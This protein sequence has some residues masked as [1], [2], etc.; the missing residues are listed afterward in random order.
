MPR[1]NPIARGAHGGRGDRGGRGGRGGR[2]GRG[3][4]GGRGGRGGPASDSGGV[5]PTTTVVPDNPGE[6]DAGPCMAPDHRAP[7]RTTKSAS[8]VETRRI[9]TSIG[10]YFR[11]TVSDKDGAEEGLID[12]V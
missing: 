10:S 9:S 8:Q 4:R 12:S 3:E 5:E 2:V 7:A 11:P 6:D 1:D